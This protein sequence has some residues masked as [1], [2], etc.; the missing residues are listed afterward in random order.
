MKAIDQYF[1]GV[2][3]IMLC[4]GILLN[5]VTLSGRPFRPGKAKYFHVVLHVLVNILRKKI[6]FIVRRS[7]EKG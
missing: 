4:R 6:E 1:H 7:G 5:F 3:F 2:L